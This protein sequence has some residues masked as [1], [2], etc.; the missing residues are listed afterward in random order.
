[1][2]IKF[3]TTEIKIEFTFSC[4]MCG[5][6]E[7]PPEKLRWILGNH[8]LALASDYDEML[9]DDAAYESMC[10]MERM[11]GHERRY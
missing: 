5:N 4:P 1:M 11:M 6:H 9:E 7:V 10:R 2:E 8:I 3:P